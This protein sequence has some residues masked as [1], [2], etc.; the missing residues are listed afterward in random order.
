MYE[1]ILYVTCCSHINNI[2]CNMLQSS[3]GSRLAVV[4]QSSGSRLAVVW[5]SSGIQQLSETDCHA[6]RLRAFSVFL[7]LLKL[8]F[9]EKDTKFDKISILVLTLLS[10]VKNKMEILSILWPCQNIIELS[11]TVYLLKVG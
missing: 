2:V 10:K 11:L 4:W 1:M 7:Y 6:M 8:R 5:Q 9:S 3:S